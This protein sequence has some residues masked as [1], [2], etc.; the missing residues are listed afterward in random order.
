MSVCMLCERA[1]QTDDQAGDQEIRGD[2]HHD[3]QDDGADDERQQSPKDW[4]NERR[5]EE[6]AAADGYTHRDLPSTPRHERDEEKQGNDSQERRGCRRLDPTM[7]ERR[8]RVSARGISLS[9]TLF[10]S[11]ERVRGDGEAKATRYEIII[12]RVHEDS[13]PAPLVE[14]V[15]QDMCVCLCS[16]KAFTLSLSLIP[17]EGYLLPSVSSLTHVLPG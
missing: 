2:H 7:S 9:L 13:A 3:H 10:L 11:G 16:K 1:F 12:M 4:E 5:R 15:A 17:R 14:A 6:E 8:T